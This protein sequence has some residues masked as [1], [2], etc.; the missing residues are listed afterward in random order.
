MNAS[1]TTQGL[2]IEVLSN[3]QFGYYGTPNMTN[4]GVS[5]AAQ[6][7]FIQAQLA[8]KHAAFEFSEDARPANVGNYQSPFVKK[9]DQ[10]SA[11]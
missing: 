3:G 11:N 2:M 4:E 8:S 9:K 1:Y 10:Y 6:K 5:N 7:A